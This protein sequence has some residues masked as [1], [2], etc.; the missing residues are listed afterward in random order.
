MQTEEVIPQLD[1]DKTLPRDEFYLLTLLSAITNEALHSKQPR[2][3]TI[4]QLYNYPHEKYP[5]LK[6]VSESTVRSKIK[7]AEKAGNQS[8]EIVDSPINTR[9]ERTLYKII[10]ILLESI[11]TG[12]HSTFKDESEFVNYLFE[13]DKLNDVEI[14]KKQAKQLVMDI[15]KDFKDLEI[16]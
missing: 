12:I 10:A 4:N 2:F 15:M 8:L 7:E 16:A 13:Q 1:K 3:K 5:D 9:T 14:T 6:G 11:L